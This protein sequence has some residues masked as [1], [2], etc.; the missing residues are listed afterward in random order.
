MG[1]AEGTVSTRPVEQE[2]DTGNNT[3]DERQDQETD[4][5]PTESGVSNTDKVNID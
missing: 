1:V 2:A 3:D 4:R 5:E